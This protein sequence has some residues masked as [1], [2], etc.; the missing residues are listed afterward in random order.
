MAAFSSG[1]GLCGVVYFHFYLDTEPVIG[2]T[3]VGREDA[4]QFDVAHPVGQMGQ[5]DS[6]RAKFHSDSH[7]FL[8]RHMTGMWRLTQTIDHKR[9]DSGKSLEALVRK[10]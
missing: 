10:A 1:T 2:G 3:H 6:L 8:N 5:K 4:F 9:S 7:G